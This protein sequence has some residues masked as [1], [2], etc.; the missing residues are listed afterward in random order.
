[1]KFSVP[2]SSLAE[3]LS[4]VNRGLSSR[5]TLPVLAGVLIA[6]EEDSITLQTTDLEISVKTRIPARVEEKGTT[7]VSGAVLLSV[8][9]SLPEGSVDFTLEKELQLRCGDATFSLMTLSADDFPK[10]PDIQEER[11]VVVEGKIL[12][13]S[14]KCVIRATSRDETRPILTGVLM[15]IE[16]ENL[17]LVATDSYRLAIKNIAVSLSSD[18][19]KGWEGDIFE[20][21]VPGRA[22]DDVMKM[23]SNDA[24]IRISV[25]DNQIAFTVGET[26]YVSRKIE[27]VFPSYKRLIPEEIKSTVELEVSALMDS[28][29]RVSL[30]AKNQ[31]PLRV[32]MNGENKAITLAASTQDIGDA[33]EIL[34]AD[35]TGEDVEVAFNHTFL[36]DGL[37]VLSAQRVRIEVSNPMKPA[38]VKGVGDESFLYLIMP[39]RPYG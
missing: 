21:V 22:L 36:A 14:V 13:E 27:G 38:L 24:R 19:K 32:S 37:S 28:T 5:S 10:F 17:R 26:V 25:S 29:R 7:V 34:P 16:Q 31:A 3:A 23:A 4:V 12:H 39:V 9:K 18:D 2:Q 15:T 8:I 35:L 30:M 6:A 33:Q 11:M 20:V 1:M